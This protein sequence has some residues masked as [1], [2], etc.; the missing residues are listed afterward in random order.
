[1]IINF[2]EC[3]NRGEREKVMAKAE[4]DDLQSQLEQANKSKVNCKNNNEIA[5][6]NSAKHFNS[7]N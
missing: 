6:C 5:F 2:N 4:M 3:Y 7:R 1:M